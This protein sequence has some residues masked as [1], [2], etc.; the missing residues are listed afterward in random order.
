MTTTSLLR[1]V[2]AD[3]ARHGRPLAAGGLGIAVS[4][5]ALVF[6]F[7]LGLG[8]RAVVV[9]DTADRDRIEVRRP[10]T[11][12]DLLAL[13]F[14]LGSDTIDEATLRRLEAIDG[15]GA[16]YPRMRLLVPAVAT[17]GEHFVGAAMQTELVG[18]GLDP[19][20]VTDTV[21]AAFHDPL[22]DDPGIGR[23]CLNDAVCPDGA[24]C[25]GA[26]VR[27]PGQCREPIPVIVSE[28]M[29]ELYNGAFRRAYK[30]PKLNP[31]AL[32]GLGLE[33]AFGASGLRSTH[34]PVRRERIVLA[35]VSDA[36]I[37]L[38]V[39]MPLGFVSRINR[40]LGATSGDGAFHAAL[41]EVANPAATAAVLDAVAA[42]GLEVGDPGS[43]RAALI[44]ATVLAVVALFGIGV[45]AVAG[46][47][48]MH[49]FALLLM[50]R[51]LEI[52][53]MRAVGASRG[54]I[55]LL[56]LTEAA[57]VG[58]IA[59][60]VGAAFA[61]LAAT[62]AD[63][64]LADWIPDLPFKPETFFAVEPRLLAAAVVLA[65]AA[66]VVGALGPVIRATVPDPA[67]VINGD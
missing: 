23:S 52:G 15:V 13:S 51:R 35:G 62:I 9:D 48:V 42:L 19:A 63:H 65:A 61:V 53:V 58:V 2:G 49:V 1:S 41:V 40:E 12:I 6:F 55:R 22:I 20:A 10:T 45:L 36:A 37:P 67:E 34:G 66:A 14:E 11:D 39:T 50:I 29:V 4:I 26:T 24:V 54:E 59:G 31:D 32:V 21:G 7:S 46:I 64:A 30:L 16:V 38:G 8:V 56:I 47:H 5:G 57:V 28:H 60:A 33:V 17:G 25:V 43:R 27:T 18:D 3:L 44:T